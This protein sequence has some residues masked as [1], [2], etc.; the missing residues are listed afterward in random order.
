MRGAAS[1][2]FCTACPA[3][4][5]GAQLSSTSPAQCLP[6]PEPAFCNTQPNGE[7][8]LCAAGHAGTFCLACARGF[9][10][11]PNGRCSPCS[12]NLYAYAAALVA[13]FALLCLLIFACRRRL[14]PYLS[15]L[16]KLWTKSAS[17]LALL[18]DQLLR[19]ALLHRLTVIPFPNVFSGMVGYVGASAGFDL[20]PAECVVA[21]TFDQ[22]YWITIG[23][24]AIVLAAV[25]A[26]DAH[27]TQAGLR[28][29][30]GQRLVFSAMDVLLPIAAQPSFAALA[31][32]AGRL[33]SDFD[34]EFA[35]A[36]H[37]PVVGFSI[38]LLVAYV[39]FLALRSGTCVRNTCKKRVVE[40]SPVATEPGAEERENRPLSRTKRNALLARYWVGFLRMFAV[41]LQMVNF[42]SPLAAS[43]WLFCVSAMEIHIFALSWQAFREEAGGGLR[44]AALLVLVFLVTNASALAC[45]LL[46]DRCATMVSLGAT[47]VALNALLAASILMP[48]CVNGYRAL[49]RRA[50]LQ[51]GA[52]AGLPSSFFTPHAIAGA[53]PLSSSGRHL[54][55][56]AFGTTFLA[57][58]APTL[59]L[60]RKP[61]PSTA[62]STASPAAPATDAEA[63]E[64][65]L[66]V[67]APAAAPAPAW[68]QWRDEVDTWY[69]HIKTGE[70]AWVLPP[71]ET[72]VPAAPP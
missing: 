5:W 67:A 47:L 61:A 55:V 8:D 19:L 22:K 30:V 26:L 21:L 23:A 50:P 3:G 69:S 39:A 51:A 65:P 71:G 6:C 32:S 58:A 59:L 31:T 2:A 53:S 44:N 27:L 45:A 56:S 34:V 4:T 20:T 54:V 29:S 12:S 15:T 72:A 9:F 42:P 7:G 10:H 25:A 68:R 40:L 70:L 52:P 17:S 28:V 48:V 36:S 64:N 33:I 41:L 37:K 18:V 43:F 14:E 38:G 60:S 46:G 13:L 57:E 35:S 49:R 63:L 24:V 1:A 16:S 62:P 66:S 11:L